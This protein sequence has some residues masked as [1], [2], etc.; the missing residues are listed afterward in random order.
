MR[1]IEMAHNPTTVRCILYRRVLGV[2]A[3]FAWHELH[4]HMPEFMSAMRGFGPRKI[5]PAG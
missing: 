3:I 1:E 4:S 2:A 5:Q